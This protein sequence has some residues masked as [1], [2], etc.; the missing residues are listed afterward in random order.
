MDTEKGSK[1]VYD[2]TW[3]IC[4]IAANMRGYLS[5]FKKNK[6]KGNTQRAIPQ[7]LW[8]ITDEIGFR[9]VTESYPSALHFLAVLHLRCVP[10]PQ[11]S[12]WLF[13][14]GCAYFFP[15]FHP[16]CHLFSSFPPTFPIT[17]YLLHL[18]AKSI[19]LSPWKKTKSIKKP[20]S[21]GIRF[22]YSLFFQNLF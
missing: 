2:T 16:P 7:A 4:T 3:T 13:V 11:I 21:S 8:P 22:F 15:T 18:T 20:A 14:L 19:F 1:R 17:P 5:L 10:R 12:G 9:L 6:W